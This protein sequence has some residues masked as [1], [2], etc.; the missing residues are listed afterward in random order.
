M[1]GGVSTARLGTTIPLCYGFVRATGMQVIL[2][3]DPQ[4]VVYAIYLL[5]EGEW[6]GYDAL[7]LNEKLYACDYVSG[8]GSVV[9]AST[10]SGASATVQFH[11]GV[12]TPLGTSLTPYSVGADQLCDNIWSAIPNVVPRSCYSRLAYYT[13][14]YHPASG[15]TSNQL[16]P[17]GDWRSMRCRIF[18]DSG[19][20]IGYQFT[21]NPAWHFVD[22]WL[23]IAIKPEYSLPL[24]VGPDAPTANEKAFFD[25]GSICEAAAYYDGILANGQKRFEG[26]YAFTSQTTLAAIHEQILLCCRSYQQEYAGKIYLNCDKPRASVFVL[27]GDHLIPGS[28][29]VDQK[30]VHKNANT[31]QSKFLDL[32]QPVVAEISAISI[33]GSGGTRSAAITTVAQHPV[34]K[35]DLF[36]CGGIDPSTLDGIYLATAATDTGITAKPIGSGTGSGTGGDIGYMQSRFS[37]R[38]PQLVHK[39]HALAQGKVLSASV[40]SRKKIPTQFD[41]ANSSFDQA[42]R[43]LKYEM[44]RDLGLDQSPWR[45]PVQITLKAWAES[46]DANWNML[47]QAQCGSRIT[48]DASA[49]WEFA[50]D[51]E[52]IE[53]RINS[54]QGDASGAQGGTT[55]RSAS[56]DSGHLELLLRTYGEDCFVDVSDAPDTY[57]A[58]VPDDGLWPGFGVVNANYQVVTITLTASDTGTSVT[59]TWSNLTIRL[60]GATLLVYADGFAINELYATLLFAFVDD[61]YARGG[62]IPLQFTTN[63]AD[64]TAAIGRMYIAAIMTPAVAGAPTTPTSEGGGGYGGTGLPPPPHYSGF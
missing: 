19:N 46:V 6:D 62:A 50:G 10:L 44:I 9:N 56:Q 15:D 11:P 49:T 14:V 35:G 43:L 31:Y 8:G 16:T 28:L 29:S 13:V 12:D 57:F 22:S 54:F 17:I 41:F 60:G 27:R 61:P 58:T 39:Q 55:A 51:Y 21:T 38:T 18:D 24:N 53:R 25:W 32:D 5:G 36:S 33:T 34:A 45:P 23:R 52:I 37:A 48:L 42:N 63:P 47:K 2:H 20:V 30:Q 3:T 26:S 4:G 40:S 59:M 1:P 7:W 64:L